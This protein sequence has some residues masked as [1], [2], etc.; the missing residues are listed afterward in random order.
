[1]F[2]RTFLEN[3]IPLK[4]NGEL[5]SCHK[6][7]VP[8]DPDSDHVSCDGQFVYD[9]SIYSQSRVYEVHI[10][11]FWLIWLFGHKIVTQC[12]ISF[13]PFKIVE[14]GLRKQM[15][16]GFDPVNLCVSFMQK[17]DKQVFALN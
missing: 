10:L 5:A 9:K 11:K 12:F 17:L 16:T 6:Y 8:F 2:N 13:L 15:G 14:H 3:Y 7:A 1:M 4:D